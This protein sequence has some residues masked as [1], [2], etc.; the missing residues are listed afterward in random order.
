[1]TIGEVNNV[2]SKF[3]QVYDNRHQYNIEWAFRD[4]QKELDGFKEKTIEGKLK[5][6]CSLCKNQQKINQSYKSYKKKAV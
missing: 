1:M 6:Q 2:F 3:D 4:A 5:N